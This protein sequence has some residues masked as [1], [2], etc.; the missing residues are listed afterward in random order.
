M[1]NTFG[2]ENSKYPSEQIRMAQFDI[3]FLLKC[4]AACWRQ[5]L[6]ASSQRGK[7]EIVSRE[8]D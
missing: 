2:N 7:G 4:N 3:V 1:C 5:S 6:F 8:S